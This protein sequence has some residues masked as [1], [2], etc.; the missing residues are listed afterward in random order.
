LKDIESW[1]YFYNIDLP[2]Y[3]TPIESGDFLNP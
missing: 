1:V 3:A 2:D